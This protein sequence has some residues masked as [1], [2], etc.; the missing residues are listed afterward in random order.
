M[1]LTGDLLHV[2]AKHVATRPLA[3]VK[4]VVI[5]FFHCPACGER[6]S[7][8]TQIAGD[9]HR[10]MNNLGAVARTLL[11]TPERLIPGATPSPCTCRN[12]LA[13][14]ESSVLCRTNPKRGSDFHLRVR[15]GTADADTF[16]AAMLF[17]DGRYVAV[18]QASLVAAIGTI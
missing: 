12:G 14:L 5:G 2:R 6:W 7:S 13:R 3:D 15:N 17:P 10:I 16:A 8:V 1:I 4:D 11:D 18:A 9:P